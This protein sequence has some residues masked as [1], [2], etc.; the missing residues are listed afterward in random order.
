MGMDIKNSV[1]VTALYDIGR[2]K[3]SNYHMSYNTYLWWMRNT[4]SLDS[5]MVIYTESKFA[6]EIINNRK[7]FDPTLEK[8]KIVVQPLEELIMYK[9][10]NN[11]LTKLMNSIEFKSKVHFHDVP[12]MCQPLY[13]VIMFNKIFFMKDVVDN[14]YFDNDVIVW[15]D[16]GGLREDVDLYKNIKWPN[17]KKINDISKNKIIFFSH[18]D[19]FEITDKEFHSLSQIRNIQGTCFLLPSILVT[20]FSELVIKIIDQS[21]VNGYIGS[22]EK[23]FDLCYIEH[24]EL[25]T[26]IKSGWRE[27]FGI[28]K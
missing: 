10:Y 21:L 11:N 2:D 7:Q 26:L 22:D 23:V 6:D 13:N 12:E 15:M 20:E 19:N 1:I 16:A 18:N 5:N 8:T 24:R 27:Y 3:W 4:L 28:L 9:K 25:F 14:N 17:L